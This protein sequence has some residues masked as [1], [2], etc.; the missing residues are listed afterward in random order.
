MLSSLLPSQ[1][2]ANNNPAKILMG[3]VTTITTLYSNDLFIHLSHHK[4]RGPIF[5]GCMPLILNTVP[6]TQSLLS[7]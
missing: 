4:G 1:C 2:W 6:G 5:F 7:H 3:G